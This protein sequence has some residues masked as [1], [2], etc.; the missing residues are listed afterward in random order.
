MS[1]PSRLGRLARATRCAAGLLVLVLLLSLPLP[2][3]AN[4]TLSATDARLLRQ[5]RI[6]FKSD[7][8]AGGTS[9]AAMGGTGRPSGG[10]WWTSPATPGC[11][12]A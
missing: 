2:V 4:L 5:G 12:R 3:N 9:D 1:V 8:P 11:S 6:L 7:I 10:R